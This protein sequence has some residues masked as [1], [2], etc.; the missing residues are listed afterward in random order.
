MAEDVRIVG[1]LAALS[2]WEL[3]FPSPIPRVAAE[4]DA[5]IEKHHRSRMSKQQKQDEARIELM[6]LSSI[7]TAERNPKKHA[8]E[9]L[10]KSLRRFGFVAPLV[11]DDSAG[12]LVAGHGR[13]EALRKMRDAGEAP[14][15]RVTVK[16]REWFAPV[17]RGVSFASAQ[18]AEAYL[19]ADNR[20][21][22]L[23]GWDQAAMAAMLED[24]LPSP[25]LIEAAGWSRREVTKL[26][27]GAR[28]KGEIEEVEPSEAPPERAKEGEVWELGKHLLAC[29][30]CREWLPRLVTTPADMLMTDP[31]YGVGYDGGGIGADKAARKKIQGDENPQAARALFVDVLAV[32]VPNLKPGSPMFVWCSSGPPQAEFATVMGAAFRQSL[33]DQGLTCLRSSRLPLAL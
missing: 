27:Q 2:W 8:I 30:D 13:L 5:Y 32:V 11:Y 15:A 4:A 16:G 31:P 20:L 12:K 1:E 22:E 29:G 18:E 9:P 26:I 7:A 21:Q 17:L 10:V 3:V 28:P 6:S 14:P 19:L 23:G 25:D 24:M 33:V